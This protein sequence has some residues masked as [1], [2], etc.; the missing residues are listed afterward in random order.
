[1]VDISK[2]D[3]EGGLKRLTFSGHQKQDDVKIQKVQ[4]EEEKVIENSDVTKEQKVSRKAELDLDYGSI[5]KK[6]LNIPKPK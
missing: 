4:I 2:N 5:A 6:K 1:M 3:P